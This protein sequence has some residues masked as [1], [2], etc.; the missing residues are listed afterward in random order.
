MSRAERLGLRVK[1][2]G[3]KSLRAPAYTWQIN[4]RQSELDLCWA[5]CRG[6]FHDTD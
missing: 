1:D 4:A 5:N 6:I 2:S 3:L